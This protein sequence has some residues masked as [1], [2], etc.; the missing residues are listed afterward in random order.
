MDNHIVTTLMIVVA[1]I[2]VVAV[3]KAI[4]PA[5]V[6]SGEAM[7]GMESR[8]TERMKSQVKI[9]HGAGELDSSHAWQDINDDGDFD[10]FIWIKNTGAL[11]ISAVESSD[12]FFGPEGNFARI[13]HQQ[14]AA[15]QYPYWTWE[16][17]NG[18][19]WDPTHTAKITI[20]HL[21]VLSSGRY[22][23]KI[24][25]PNGLCAEDYLGM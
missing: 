4:Y 10:V 12:L 9:I 18:T 8:I 22:L 13:P 21:A 11:R 7:A 23:V 20:H 24:V 2:C 1:M 16:V 15:G 6:Q 3:F 25:L 5:V 17:E 14:E 19:A